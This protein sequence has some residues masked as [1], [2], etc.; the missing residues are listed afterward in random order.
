MAA[1]KAEALLRCQARVHVVASRVGAEVRRLSGIVTGPASLTWEERP[2]RPGELAS[3]PA[4]PAG[5]RYWLVM[6]AVDD[7]M[8]S[9]AVAD[10][11]ERAGMWVNVADD[12]EACSFTLPS[13]L[14]QGQ[15]TVTVATAGQSPALASWLRDRLAGEVG[16]EYSVLAGLLSEAREELRQRG[17]PTSG[18]DWQTVLDS[19]MLGLVRAGRVEEARERLKACL[20]LS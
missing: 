2:W 3:G 15:V 8:V 17:R 1:R 13:V 18:L 5:R 6:V 10:E 20:S 12:A 16:P 11:A 7:P 19:D 14:R 9:R 4:G